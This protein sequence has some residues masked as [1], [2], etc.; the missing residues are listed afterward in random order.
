MERY[1]DECSINEK[2]EFAAIE[3]GKKYADKLLHDGKVDK[4]TYETIL[5]ELLCRL[6]DL[7]EKY[8][9]YV[10]RKVTIYI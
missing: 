4:D 7:E 6:D 1:W 9:D 5:I 8:N 2:L 3:R 10:P